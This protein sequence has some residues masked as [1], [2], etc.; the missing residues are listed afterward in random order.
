[1]NLIKI[2]IVLSTIIL[3]PL[4]N[5]ACS[6]TNNKLTSL[7]GLD[8]ANGVVYA[9]LTSSLNQCSCSSVRFNPAK[10][11]TKMA[12]GILLAAKMAEKEVRIDLTDENDCNSAYR[13]YIQ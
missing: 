2:S 4:S 5:A 3:S 8:S 6:Q 10:T 9:N 13:V 12:L 1:M 7:V 11:D